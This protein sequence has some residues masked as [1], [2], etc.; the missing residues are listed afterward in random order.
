MRAAMHERR[1]SLAFFQAVVSNFA[2]GPRASERLD[3]GL[4]Q[5]D[6]AL[7]V[8]RRVRIFLTALD[9]LAGFPVSTVTFAG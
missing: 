4:L 6:E 2:D 9:R 8:V 5:I 7:Q 1:R 3:T